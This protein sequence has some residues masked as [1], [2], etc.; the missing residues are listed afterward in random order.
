[1]RL[2][3]VQPNDLR[4][5]CIICILPYLQAQAQL[6]RQLAEIGKGGHSGTSFS[7]VQPHGGNVRILLGNCS[8]KASHLL[9]RPLSDVRIELRTS[10][11]ALTV[12]EWF[13]FLEE[14]ISFFGGIALRLI[15]SASTSFISRAGRVES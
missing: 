2:N 8:S 13:V 14:S 10:T 11:G 9:L 1:V 7:K 5:L 15:I 4:F 12:I 6:S 3:V